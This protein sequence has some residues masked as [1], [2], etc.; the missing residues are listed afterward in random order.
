[1][2]IL[3]N[4]VFWVVIFAIIFILAVIGYITESR[5]K[6]KK[7]PV[8]LKTE[9]IPAA[10]PTPPVDNSNVLSPVDS[11]AVLNL[12][13]GTWNNNQP[14]ENVAVQSGL[15]DD[16]SVMPEVSNSNVQNM[17][18][19][20]SGVPFPAS[21]TPVVEPAPVAEPVVET[22]AVEPAPV[23][24]PVVE[25][26]AVEPAPVA[27]PVVETPVVEATPVVEPASEAPVVEAAPTEQSDTDIWK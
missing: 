14:V 25:T 16:W 24:E 8:E 26:P 21:E 11:G 4:W 13:N 7:A 27:E 6:E 17:D 10:A 5:K 12:D 18:A 15:A 2:S 1:M 23:A 19:S 3:S 22:P 20:Q 9:A